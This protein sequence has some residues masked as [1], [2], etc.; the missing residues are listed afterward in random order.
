[1]AVGEEIIADARAAIN[2]DEAVQDSVRTEDDIVVDETV[3]PNVRIRTDCRGFRDD[4]GG[5]NAGQ[6]ARSLME[7]PDGVSESEIGIRSAQKG[8]RKPLFILRYDNGRGARLGYGRPIAAIGEKSQLSR[9]G[10]FDS[11]NAGD[12]DLRISV[13]R[14]LQARG[15]FSESHCVLP[16]GLDVTMR[17]IRKDILK[18]ALFSEEF[19]LRNGRNGGL[20]SRNAD[21]AQD[22]HFGKGR[23]RNENPKAIAVKIRGRKTNTMHEK[24]EQI[25]RDDSLEHVIVTEAKAY[26]ETVEL[27]TAEEGFALRLEVVTKL[28][29]EVDALDLG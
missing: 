29:N 19:G 26:P 22:F 1:M 17:N 14:A 4:G 7:K 20:A 18:R 24:V 3:R 5:M 10:V 16:A 15:N 21:D 9:F 12:F 2:A 23:A 13:E 8:Q 28:P 11:G 6:I 27:G 25:V